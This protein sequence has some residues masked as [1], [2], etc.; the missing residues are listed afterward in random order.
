MINTVNVSNKT[1]QHTVNHGGG[2]PLKIQIV[3]YKVKQ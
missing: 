2:L 1:C 3:N